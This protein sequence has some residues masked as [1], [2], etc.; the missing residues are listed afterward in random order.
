[1]P[2]SSSRL[3]LRSGSDLLLHRGTLLSPASL[4]IYSP[5]T[6]V[7]CCCPA[8]WALAVCP[9]PSSLA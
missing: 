2:V 9:L 4:C 8:S 3:P 7:S 5:G 6:Q 1:M